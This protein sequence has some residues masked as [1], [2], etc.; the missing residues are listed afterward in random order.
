MYPMGGSAFIALC[1]LATV[2]AAGGAAAQSGRITAPAENP[3]AG[4]SADRYVD[5]RGC[6]FLRADIGGRESWVALMRADR[7]PVCDAT[8]RMAAAPA[9]APV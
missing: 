2:V 8:P 9:V 7:T 5:S 1:L 3:P 4:D 6:V